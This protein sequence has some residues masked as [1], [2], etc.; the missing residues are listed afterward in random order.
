MDNYVLSGC[1]AILLLLKSVDNT[2]HTCISLFLKTTLTPTTPS[3]RSKHKAYLQILLE[4][5]LKESKIN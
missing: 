4:D 2:E 1:F 5:F 3:I